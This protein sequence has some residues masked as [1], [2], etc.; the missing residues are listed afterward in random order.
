[1]NK[2]I[3]KKILFALICGIL[4]GIRIAIQTMVP[5]FPITNSDVDDLLMVSLASRM[6]FSRPWLGAYDRYTL[7]K[8]PGYSIFLKI[9]NLFNFRYSIFLG[10]FYS[11]ACLLFL[12]AMYRFTKSKYKSL[13]AFAIVLY[14]PVMLDDE[15]GGRLYCISLVPL[16]TIAIIASYLG[17]IADRD[18]NSKMTLWLIIGG[19]FY[20]YY[21]IIRYDY[22]WITGFIVAVSVLVMV[23]YLIEYKN[24]LNLKKI[25]IRLIIVLIPICM[26]IVTTNVLRFIN[27]R[28]YGVYVT[29]DFEESNFAKM[30]KLL[31]SIEPDKEIDGVYVSMN[32]IEKAADNSPNLK[33]LVDE[34]EKTGW[35]NQTEDGDVYI[36]FYAWNLRSA[37]N[38]LGIYKDAK[39]AND[40]YGQIC[41]DLEKAFDDGILEKRKALTISPFS[42]PLKMSDIPDFIDYSVK[43]GLYSIISYNYID[44]GYNITNDSSFDGRVIAFEDILNEELISPDEIGNVLLEGW[45][46]AEND[47]DEISLSIIDG[48]GNEYIADFVDSPDVYNAH[49]KENAK[50]AR[51]SIRLNGKWK[52]TDNVYVVIKLNDEVV[53]E[54]LFKDFVNELD[55]EGCNYSLDKVIY[56]RYKDN[57]VSME[58]DIKDDLK[59]LQACVDFFKAIAVFIIAICILSC[60]V[61]LIINI[62]NVVKKKK[63]D[64]LPLILKL[65][66]FLTMWINVMMQSERNFKGGVSFGSFYS[67][68]AYTIYS[69]FVAFCIITF[70]ELLYRL[71]K[72]VL[73]KS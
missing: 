55:I 3:I 43:V 34:R 31:M 67:S 47:D 26:G 70:I 20:S 19:A 10:V 60:I 42:A 53:Y 27:Y 62:Y 63:A 28:S 12:Y 46:Y 52:E 35:S 11:A 13:I 39:Y 57:I 56:P 21:R 45:I 69:I 29:S 24:A 15:V 44:V 36:D 17:A 6:K 23:L 32:A 50:K 61:E 59:F 66:L 72:R 68:G 73:K 51:F 16:C 37:A 71:F 4:V 65:G 5:M 38:N 64:F 2:D 25:I 8:L 48:N 49:K 41:D 1:M 18:K 54:S 33:K 22:I 14:C 40:F 58:E 9:N 30:C 7:N